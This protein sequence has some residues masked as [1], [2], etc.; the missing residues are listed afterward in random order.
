MSMV[1]STLTS[2]RSSPTATVPA[3]P[4]KRPRTFVSPKWRPTKATSAWPGS[5]CQTPAAGRF[6]PSS[7]RVGV[8]TLPFVWAQIMRASARNIHLRVYARKCRFGHVTKDIDR[9][10]AWRAVL[11]AQSRVVRAIERDLDAAGAISLGWSDVL[12]RAQRSARSSAANA[13]ARCATV[14]SRTRISR[15]VSELE[16]RGRWSVAGDPGR[17]S[18]LACHAH[19]RRQGRAAKR[20]APLYMAGIERHFNDHLT[21]QA[22]SAIE[23]SLQPV[24]DA[25]QLQLDPRR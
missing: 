14:L 18:R 11:L 12:P 1:T 10:G 16:Q 9:V 7:V 20:T 17:R 25:H 3:T 15:I 21:S 23:R 6:T 2:A 8:M 22:R 4:V 19:R 24:I 13:R 5:I